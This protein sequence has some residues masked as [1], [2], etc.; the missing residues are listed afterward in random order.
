[1]GHSVSSRKYVW[2]GRA[3]LKTFVPTRNNHES[4][5]WEVWGPFVPP[6]TSE[7][8]N[9]RILLRINIWIMF[10]ANGW[11]LRS[12]FFSMSDARTHSS[13]TMPGSPP[14]EISGSGPPMLCCANSEKW[15]R[16]CP[17]RVVNIDMHS[18]QENSAFLGRVSF[19]KTVRHR[20][21]QRDRHRKP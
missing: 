1:M 11:K 14:G 3:F 20:S 16:G 17:P 8:W 7:V 13:P 10:F 12:S 5:I 18:D 4:D 19:L 15:F 2:G 6:Q 21:L 9:G